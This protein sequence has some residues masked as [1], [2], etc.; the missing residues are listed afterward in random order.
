MV[1]AVEAHVHQRHVFAKLQRCR[2]ILRPG[3]ELSKSQVE[4]SHPADICDIPEAA[5]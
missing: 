3:I 4:A 2:N 1:R 5:A